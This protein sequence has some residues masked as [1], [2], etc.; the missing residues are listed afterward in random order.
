MSLVNTHKI[1]VPPLHIKKNIK[2]I[3]YDD[4]GV[5]CIKVKLSI[6]KNKTKLKEDISIEPKITELMPDSKF[7]TSKLDPFELVIW[8]SFMLLVN[9]AKDPIDHI[10]KQIKVSRPVESVA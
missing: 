3:A 7:N 2:A 1:F 9:M 5:Q 10:K 8:H 6:E 4:C